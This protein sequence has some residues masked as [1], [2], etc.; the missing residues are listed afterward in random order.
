V[1]FHTRQLAVLLFL[2]LLCLA[3]NPSQASADPALRQLLKE[4]IE[5]DSG[6]EDR[7]D[8]QVTWSSF[9]IHPS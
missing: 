2:S 4:A 6:F 1:A 9:L 8:A 5:S 3:P 7:F